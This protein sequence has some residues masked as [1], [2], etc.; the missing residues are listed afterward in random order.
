MAWYIMHSAMDTKS[1]KNKASLEQTMLNPN[2]SLKD[3]RDAVRQY[4]SLFGQKTLID[5]ANK[6][7]IW[8]SVSNVIKDNEIP[9]SA[10]NGQSL[11]DAYRI[12]GRSGREYRLRQLK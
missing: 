1:S 4:E 5:F 11:E 3:F 10:K 2:V 6:N 8:S 12:G 7:G 9:T